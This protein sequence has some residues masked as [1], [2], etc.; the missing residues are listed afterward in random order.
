MTNVKCLVY[1]FNFILIFL[2]PV[3]RTLKCKQKKTPGPR[4]FAVVLRVI[5]D[6]SRWPGIDTK[7]ASKGVN[8]LSWLSIIL[9][10]TSDH[11]DDYNYFTIFILFLFYM[12]LLKLL[13]FEKIVIVF[14]GFLNVLKISAFSKKKKCLR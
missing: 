1:L 7:F 11:I 13:Y 4:W 12:D 14:V 6:W 8:G 5:P 3:F 2:A 10:F 9:D